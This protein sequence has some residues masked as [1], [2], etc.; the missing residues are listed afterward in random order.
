MGKDDILENVAEG[1]NED[2]QKDVVALERSMGGKFL[3]TFHIKTKKSKFVKDGP[4]WKDIDLK[5]VTASRSLRNMFGGLRTEFP[6][7]TRSVREAMATEISNASNAFGQLVSSLKA[8]L[9]AAFGTSAKINKK[10]NSYLMAEL[11]GQLSAEFSAFAK[12]FGALGDENY[13]FPI[14]ETYVDG[15]ES[16]VTAFSEGAARSVK[17][18]LGKLKSL[19]SDATSTLN[20]F[21]ESLDKNLFSY[22]SNPAGEFS[23]LGLRSFYETEIKKLK[24]S[25]QIAGGS[26]SVDETDGSGSAE[27]GLDENAPSDGDPADETPSK[28]NSKKKHKNKKK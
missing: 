10:G 8:G 7:A 13:E 16:A 3:E 28:K 1:Q 12:S 27:L 18:A 14:P 5:I 23:P 25:G 6:Y 11:I 20:P 15:L 2:P 17:S 4:T 21:A 9:A 22:L 24:N 19:K 26:A